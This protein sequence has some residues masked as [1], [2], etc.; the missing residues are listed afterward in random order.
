MVINY[1]SKIEVTDICKAT[2][3][4][5]NRFIAWQEKIRTAEEKGFKAEALLRQKKLEKSQAVAIQNEYRRIRNSA[6][7]DL[8]S[9]SKIDIRK[10]LDS[11][12]TM[13][14][15][16]KSHG[17]FKIKRNLFVE[18]IKVIFDS[19]KSDKE[20]AKIFFE[21]LLLKGVSKQNYLNLTTLMC[22]NKEKEYEEEKDNVSKMFNKT[23]GVSSRKVF[24]EAVLEAVLYD[25][26]FKEVEREFTLYHLHIFPEIF[27]ILSS[28]SQAQRENK[29]K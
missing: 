15:L 21:K 16:I 28:F 19:I 17:E 24:E 26:L 5:F 6:V 10:K 11:R 7:K 12:Q 29:K 8:Y 2:G 23:V 18:D 1:K 4:P 9:V 22:K 13:L 20:L 14:L 3:Y 25:Y 27:I